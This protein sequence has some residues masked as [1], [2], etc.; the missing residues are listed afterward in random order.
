MTHASCSAVATVSHGKKRSTYIVSPGEQNAPW[1]SLQLPVNE[2]GHKTS[3]LIVTAMPALALVSNV[4]SASMVE[5]SDQTQNASSVALPC[6]CVTVSLP[7][8][9]EQGERPF[10]PPLFVGWLPKRMISIVPSVLKCTSSRAG[11]CIPAKVYRGD[12]AAEANGGARLP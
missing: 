11:A 6:S 2:R 10:M 3:G 4:S 8:T 12:A 9:R 5:S 7:S 1:T